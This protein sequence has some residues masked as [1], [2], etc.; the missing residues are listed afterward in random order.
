MPVGEHS[1][2]GVTRGSPSVTAPSVVMRPAW[3]P[4]WSS[5]SVNQSAPSGPAAMYAGVETLGI[6][7]SVTDPA[8]VMRPM[9]WG[10]C[11][12]NHSA[13]SGP[14]AIPKAVRP[15]GGVS[16][17]GNAP[18]VLGRAAVLA[19]LPANHNGSARATA[20]AL[21]PVRLLRRL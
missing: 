3:S 16:G 9:L 6:G 21:G 19:P 18:A 17:F 11:S 4:A 5:T 2:S 14:A 7:C 8:V 13:P 15:P 12:V 1:T 20:E 10:V